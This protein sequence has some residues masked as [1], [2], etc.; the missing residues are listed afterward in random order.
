MFARFDRHGTPLYRTDELIL[1]LSARMRQRATDTASLLTSTV[2]A[3]EHHTRSG[4]QITFFLN[5]SHISQSSQ[6][7]IFASAENI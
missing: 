7:G 2:L 5:S 1:N 6:V 4:Y 3:V